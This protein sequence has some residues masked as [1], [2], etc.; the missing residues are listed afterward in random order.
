MRSL[1]FVAI[2]LT[3]SPSFPRKPC[4]AS[5]FSVIKQTFID[6]SPPSAVYP[7]T[8]RR[9]FPHPTRNARTDERGYTILERRRRCITAGG[10]VTRRTTTELYSSWDNTPVTAPSSSS[11]SAE[12]ANSA[13][14]RARA[15]KRQAAKT[16]LEAE[17]MDLVLTLEKIALLE[18]KVDC[19]STLKNPDKVQDIYDQIAVLKRKLDAGKGP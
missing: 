8:H 14:A 4:V 12:D 5:G 2:L 15:L 6:T 19:Q 13:V 7:V 3:L 1:N 10:G 11:S 17:K 16:R 9:A 18:T